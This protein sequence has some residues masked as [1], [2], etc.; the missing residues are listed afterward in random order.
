MILFFTDYFSGPARALDRVCVCYAWYT[1]A[2][3]TGREHGPWT[4][5]SFWT[6][7]NT[8]EIDMSPIYWTQSDPTHYVIDPTQQCI[9]YLDPTKPTQPDRNR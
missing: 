4:R 1:L 6:P 3:S 8:A 9:N 5:A 7:V 2:V